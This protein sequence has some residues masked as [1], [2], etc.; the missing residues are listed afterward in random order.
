MRNFKHPASHET[1]LPATGTW[2]EL[3]GNSLNSRSIAITA[4][5]RTPHADSQSTKHDRDHHGV[6][7]EMPKLGGSLKNEEVEVPTADRVP[8]VWSVC[9]DC[10]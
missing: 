1:G 8:Y 6:G 10:Y 4:T 9:L 5:K 7:P 3:P 2:S